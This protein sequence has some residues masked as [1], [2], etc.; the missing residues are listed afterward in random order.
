MAPPNRLLDRNIRFSDKRNPDDFLGGLVQNGSVTET[1]FLSMLNIVLVASSPIRVYAKATG[2]P[3][4]QTDTPL[5]LGDYIVACDDQ[6]H[7]SNEPWLHRVI[8]HS[9]SGREDGFRD[10]I[11]ARDRKCVI[12]GV[13]NTRSAG[14][15]TSFEAAHIFPLELENL[16]IEFNY[17]RWVDDIDDDA[18]ISKINSCQNGFLLQSTVHKA[19][20][21]YLLSVNPDDNYKITV[22]DIDIFGFDGRVLDPAC[23]NPEDPHRVSDHLLRWHFRQSVLANMRRAGEP[24]FEHDFPPGT[25]M[26]KEIREGPYAQ[27]R[28]EKELAA[29]FKGVV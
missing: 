6:I 1:N 28:F 9:V 14:N 20:D 26:M 24:I 12:S 25:D 10:G 22:F 23:L 19:F 29:R 7:V 11:R 3:V 13:V 16:W 18:G 15:W 5:Q 4:L 21:Q 2:A 17:G 8:S 27:E